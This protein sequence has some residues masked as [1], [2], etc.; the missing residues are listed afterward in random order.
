LSR[1]ASHGLGSE[2]R[3]QPARPE[4][5]MIV[6]LRARILLAVIGAILL[7]PV[8]AIPL[9]DKKLLER[10]HNRSLA[11]WPSV[12]FLPDP[13][14]YAAVA[15]KWIDDRAYPIVQA[16]TIQN[17][18]RLFVLRTPPYR[19]VTLGRDGFIFLNGS[20]E[21]SVYGLFA[22]V[23]IHDHIPAA[24]DDFKKSLG[25]MAAFARD[26]G[27]SIDVVVLPTLISL[28]GD[29]LPSSVPE[30]YRTACAARA[31]GETPLLHIEPP[32]PLHYV[33]PF[34]EMRAARG[35]EPF[36]PKG[37][38]HPIGLSLKVARDAYLVS[39]GAGGRVDGDILEHDTA[40]SEV[41]LDHG[42]VYKYYPL[43]RL[44]APH[45]DFDDET[46]AA[47]RR[48][49]APLFDAPLIDTHAY[50]NSH[51]V[52]AQTSLMLSD[53]FGT[54]ASGV[55]AGGFRRLLHVGINEMR[56][57]DL[58]ELID[59]LQAIA[60]IDRLIFLVNDG[61]VYSLTKYGRRLGRASLASHG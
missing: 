18:F 35:D 40:P 42:R 44:H 6:S 34:M 48:V 15:A 57:E 13:A 22:A 39:L 8:A 9:Q 36:F 7:V 49:L 20:D 41:L 56:E 5:A 51:P 28:Y 3:L 45:V 55:F 37:N 25:L 4:S 54:L 27:I 12:G 43:Y 33:F 1:G 16:A 24:M 23:C 21:Q 31:A 60:S 17:T 52:L 32:A 47:I 10:F 11:P 38:F 58:V 30:T 14:R 46:N 53:S 2:Q 50:T 26:R 61:N 19:R 59:R 29:Y